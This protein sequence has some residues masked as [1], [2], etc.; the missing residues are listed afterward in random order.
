MRKRLALTTGLKVVDMIGPLHVD[1][2]NQERCLL[3]DV[4]IRI[5]LMR[6][7]T[8]FVLMMSP[9]DSD[10]QINVLEAILHARKMKISTAVMN[11]HSLALQK[12]SAKYPIRRRNVCYF[13]IPKGSSNMSPSLY[14]LF[15]NMFKL[16][17]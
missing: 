11:A 3:N 10:I 1:F 12:T 9:D 5:N 4:D 14:K 8:K 6:H 7:N 17:W 13:T 15:D 2:F 16:V